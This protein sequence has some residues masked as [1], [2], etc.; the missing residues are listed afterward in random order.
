V[1]GGAPASFALSEVLG[2]LSYA[3]D[4]TEG[5]PPGHAVRTL[6]IGMRLAEQLR[7]GDDVRS[8]SWR[9]PRGSSTSRAA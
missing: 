4:I 5:E 1:R 7:L 8:A 6:A 3:L 9:S 2:A